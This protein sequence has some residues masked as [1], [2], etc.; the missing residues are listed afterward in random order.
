MNNG[1]QR[2]SLGGH[3]NQLSGFKVLHSK[4]Y[5][6]WPDLEWPEFLESCKLEI[7]NG[8]NFT[9]ARAECTSACD[10][11]SLGSVGNDKAQSAKCTCAAPKTTREL[12]I[13]TISNSDWFK[14]FH[15]KS[16]PFK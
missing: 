6:I 4:F 1:D 13:N 10:V 7:W 15:K 5:K 14:L 8:E 3:N 12:K 2:S 11:S 16:L 9:G